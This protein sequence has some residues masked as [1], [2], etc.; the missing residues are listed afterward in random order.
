MR[1]AILCFVLL[2]GICSVATAQ[3]YTCSGGSCGISAQYYYP[4]QS[5]YYIQ[6]QKPIPPI[7]LPPKI[8]VPASTPPHPNYPDKPPTAKPGFFPVARPHLTELFHRNW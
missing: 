7:V 4:R 8:I 3:R 1:S 5:Y 6:Q 2:L